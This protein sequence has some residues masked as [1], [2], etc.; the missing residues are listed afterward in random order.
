MTFYL[1]HFR[2]NIFTSIKFSSIILPHLGH[3]ET[4][5]ECKYPRESK[6]ISKTSYPH[7]HNNDVGSIFDFFNFVV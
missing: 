3:L 2:P 4:L 6:Y 7:S 1:V 5:A